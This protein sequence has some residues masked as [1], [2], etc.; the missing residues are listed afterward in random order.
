MADPESFDAD[1]DPALDP[2]TKFC[3]LGRQKISNLHFFPLHNL[4]KLILC[5]FRSNNAGGGVRGEG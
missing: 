4:T 1:P 5:K 2:D 3:S